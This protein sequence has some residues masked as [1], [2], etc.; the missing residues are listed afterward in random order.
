VERKKVELKLQFYSLPEAAKAQ[1]RIN[2]Y[3]IDYPDDSEDDDQ[4]FIDIGS[5]A[6]RETPVPRRRVARGSL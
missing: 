5:F 1:F 4:P 3:T 2:T 6:Y